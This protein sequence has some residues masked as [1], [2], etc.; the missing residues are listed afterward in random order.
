LAA[1]IGFNPSEKI[2]LR[3]DAD[4]MA[5]GVQHRQATD[6]MLKHEV[7]RLQD[8]CLR[9]QRDDIARHDARGFHYKLQESS[10]QLILTG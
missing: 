6:P 7:S 2:A 5:I 3:D 8:R 1:R 10:F 9:L 4:D